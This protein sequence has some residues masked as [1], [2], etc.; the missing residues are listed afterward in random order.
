MAMARRVVV[1]LSICVNNLSLKVHTYWRL[2]LLNLWRVF[3]YRVS[4]KIGLNPV[5]RLKAAPPQG[6]FFRKRSEF[7]SNA[8]TSTATEFDSI[9]LFG[10]YPFSLKRAHPPNWFQSPFTQEQVNTGSKEWWQISD[11]GLDIGDI[12]QI[13]E[14]SRFDWVIK[15]AQQASLGDMTSH[16]QLELW[17]QDWIKSNPPYQGVNWKCGQEA[18]IRVLHLIVAARI[19]NSLQC[20]EQGLVELIHLHLQR[21]A[22]TL[23]YAMAQDNNHG[24]SEAAAMYVGGLF[25]DSHGIQQGERWAELGRKWLENRVR[26]LID[27]DGSFSQYSVN[28]HRLMLDT[29][30]LSELACQWFNDARF[31]QDF[32]NKAQAATHWLA[33]LVEPQ[34]GDVPNL[35]ANDGARLIPLVSAGYR[36]Y[37]P[38]V[39]FASTVF[40]NAIPSKLANCSSSSFEILQW[41]GLVK[42]AASFDLPPYQLFEQGGYAV[43][44]NAHAKAVIRYP[45][46]KFRPS[47]ND[48]LHLDFWLGHENL[49]RDAGS[50][51]YNC[52][53]P[54]QSYFPSV[55]AHNTIEFDEREQM[56]RISR[57]LLGAWPTTK[58][59]QANSFE[60]ESTSFSCAYLDAWGASH[61]REV[62]LSESLLTITD[63]VRG[64]NKIAVA[65]YRLSPQRS[66]TIKGNEISDGEHLI[67]ITADVPIAEMRLVTGWESRYYFKKTQLPV[68]EVELHQQGSL[69]MEYHWAL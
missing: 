17:L 14:L 4:V 39:V 16:E 3:W 34:T 38:S 60:D 32:Y 67:R 43:L 58:F 1:L 46:F 56:P 19:L 29:L 36:D 49:L 68:L 50:Y 24:T 35:G 27:A 48:L 40:C 31:S 28:Y 5:R 59:I 21:I 41:F 15:R 22:P 63:T 2:G 13:W 55:A 20:T 33:T 9:D 18:S 7:R 53:E 51:S 61:Q 47:Q 10:H 44:S 8:S 65:R 64:F 30:C 62:L 37:R 52:D 45:R 54:W 11:F 42:P 66:W 57:F 69:T 26:R 6:P 23:S 25:L 12:K